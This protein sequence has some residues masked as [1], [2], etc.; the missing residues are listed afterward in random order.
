MGR[1]QPQ[2]VPGAKEVRK[3]LDVINR[4]LPFVVQ[5]KV[6]LHWETDIEVRGKEAA[7]ERMDKLN[8]LDEGKRLGQEKEGEP[9][10]PVVERRV[11]SRDHADRVQE[12]IRIGR[13]EAATTPR[14]RR[15]RPPSM[16]MPEER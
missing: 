15:T 14:P 7:K 6:G 5:R 12:G 13:A 9:L 16:Y 1:E 3:A 10:D 2:R 11:I 4:T 8:A